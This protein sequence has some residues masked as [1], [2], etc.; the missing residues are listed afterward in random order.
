MTSIL[1]C[2][3]CSAKM[4][5]ADRT[6]VHGKPLRCSHCHAVF[7]AAAPGD[8]PVPPHH[9]TN[10]VEGPLAPGG[11]PGQPSLEEAG[12]VAPTHSGKRL[13]AATTP[14]KRMDAE[15]AADHAPRR[16]PWLVLCLMALLGGGWFFLRPPAG[17]SLRPLYPVEGHVLFN[18]EPAAHVKVR[19]L[20]L[21]D[22]LDRYGPWGEVDDEGRFQLSTYKK[23][24]GAPLGRYLVSFS[25]IVE[26]PSPLPD[27]PWHVTTEERLPAKYTKP[28]TSGYEV[29]IK[30]GNNVLGPFE[31]K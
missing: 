14:P 20:P 25:L 26:K 28:N 19:L 12:F 7:T 10:T 16:L 29:E 17:P 22:S 27:N 8:T 15:T 9:A 31:L 21:E 5:V 30:A 3:A 23:D 11:A 6:E 13:S 2:P 4:T 1:A 18:G 24:D